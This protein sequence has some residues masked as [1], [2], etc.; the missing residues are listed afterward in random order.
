MNSHK[1]TTEMK[2]AARE[3]LLGKY[4][5]YIGAAL[6]IDSF[7]LLV[8]MIASSVLPSDNL[9]GNVLN[10]AISFVLEL[11]A[12]VFMLGLIHFTLNI[13]LNR[14]YKISNIFYGFTSHPDKAII[15][16]FLFLIAEL[17][18]LLPAGVFFLLYYITENALLMILVSLL[19]VIG[20]IAAVII[21][22][23]FYFVYYLILD[24]PDASIKE[25]FIYC[26]NMMQ[27]Q[28][29]K[30]FYLYAS[31]LPLYVL[32][33]LSLGIGI[34]FVTPYVNVTIAQFYLD[35]FHNENEIH[36][37]ESFETE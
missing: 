17:V 16:K 22:L 4:R 8:S 28:R 15:S 26:G 3:L 30:F 9:W 1:T 7:I 13:C 35:V 5:T 14:P 36:T 19:G 24:Y 25:L 10:F 27:G 2:S 23:S 33:F 31:F 34:L 20:M 37:N 6:I 11:I 32:G 21:H 29:I 18:C 12:S